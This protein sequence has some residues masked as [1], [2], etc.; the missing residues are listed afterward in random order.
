MTQHIC[1]TA[2][3]GPASSYMQSKA[4]TARASFLLEPRRSRR[5]NRRRGMRSPGT[6]GGCDLARIC[7]RGILP[8]LD[9][10]NYHLGNGDHSTT[11]ARLLHQPVVPFFTHT[12]VRVKDGVNTRCAGALF[13]V[14]WLSPEVQVPEK[15]VVGSEQNRRA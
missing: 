12:F 13:G 11:E 4:R 8:F 5:S 3:N 9:G 7:T 15:A 2:A 6:I 1:A 14:Q 10:S